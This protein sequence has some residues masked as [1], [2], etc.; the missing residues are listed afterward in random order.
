M[1][2]QAPKP[3]GLVVLARLKSEPALKPTDRAQAPTHRREDAHVLLGS[4]EQAKSLAYGNRD[5]IGEQNDTIY[6][7]MRDLGTVLDAMAD[8]IRCL[9]PMADRTLDLVRQMK[10]LKTELEMEVLKRRGY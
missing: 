9:Q 2:D 10:N 8:E 3:R 5:I 7:R 6:S 4:D 1:S